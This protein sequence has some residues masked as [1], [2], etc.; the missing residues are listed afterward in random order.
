MENWTSSIS[1]ES[2]IIPWQ[3]PHVHAAQRALPF[4]SA[5]S[6][7]SSF[8]CQFPYFLL[9]LTVLP[10]QV[11]CVLDFHSF[12][13]RQWLAW[14]SLLS[15]S[16]KFFFIFLCLP[17]K[18]SLISHHLYCFWLGSVNGLWLSLS[19]QNFPGLLSVTSHH[20]FHLVH[21]T[22]CHLL[23]LPDNHWKRDIRLL[24]RAVS[25]KNM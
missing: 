24:F 2:S 16:Y 14:I 11:F 7:L 6:Y 3:V 13:C 9:L 15:P 8:F 12:S 25:V 18:L 22:S 4:S 23:S 10:A 1:T 20:T 19:R 5:S 21:H 17:V